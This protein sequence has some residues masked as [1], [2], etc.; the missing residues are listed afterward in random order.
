M[1]I[2]VVGAGQR[3]PPCP[4]AMALGARQRGFGQ[5]V[6]SV[7]RVGCAVLRLVEAQAVLG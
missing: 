7:Q 6:G 1:R 3:V 5:A 2:Q 4:Q